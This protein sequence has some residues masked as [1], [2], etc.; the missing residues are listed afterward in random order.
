LK[1][2]KNSRH[3]PAFIML[4]LSRGSNYGAA[5]L[6][7]MEEDLPYFMGDSA[8]VYRTLHDLEAEGSV[9]TKWLTPENGPPKKYYTLTDKGRQR[10]LEYEQ[11]IIKRRE[12]FNY[13]LKSLDTIKNI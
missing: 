4:F 12:N 11:D 10:L 13:F 5:L 6:S 7:A 1:N 9:E 2:S 3:A 8:M